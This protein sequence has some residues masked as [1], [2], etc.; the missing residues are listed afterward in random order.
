[1]KNRRVTPY[2]APN[3]SAYYTTSS[4][5]S[6]AYQMPYSVGQGRN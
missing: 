5:L 4:P 2:P 1:M 3:S 6:A